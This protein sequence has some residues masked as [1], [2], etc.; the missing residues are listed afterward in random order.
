[1][2][3]SPESLREIIFLTLRPESAC[4]SWN[5]GNGW[6]VIERM[7]GGY[8]WAEIS[9]AREGSVVRVSCKKDG[10]MDTGKRREVCRN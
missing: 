6:G 9:T 5:D 2:A 7:K 10:F 8:E 4:A 1:M 3:V